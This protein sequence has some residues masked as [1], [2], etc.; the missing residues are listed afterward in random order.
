MKGGALCTSLQGARKA[1]VGST[2]YHIV[3]H[4][5]VEKQQHLGVMLIIIPGCVVGSA[6][7]NSPCTVS[8]SVQAVEGNA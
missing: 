2:S 3:M 5:W 7:L 1:V 4:C 6:L 8:N